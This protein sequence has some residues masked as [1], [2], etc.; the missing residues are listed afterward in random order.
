MWN[1]IWAA[2]TQPARR[3]AP[4]PLFVDERLRPIGR[5]F[6]IALVLGAGF[7]I[8]AHWRDGSQLVPLIGMSLL[9]ALAFFLLGAALG[10]VFALPRTAPANDPEPQG[11]R[12]GF[13][14]NLIEVSDWITKSIVALS[15]ANLQ[16]VPEYFARLGGYFGNAE[17]G[18]SHHSLAVTIIIAGLVAGF[19]MGYI[20]TQAYLTRVFDGVLRELSAEAEGALDR[21][22]LAAQSALT[23]DLGEE[24]EPVRQGA[25]VLPVEMLAAAR[26]ESI[27]NS[28]EPFDARERMLAL[29]REYE[30]TRASMEGGFARTQAMESVA[31]KMRATALAAAPWL[32]QFQSAA[33][34]GA[35]LAAIAILQ[36]RPQAGSLG[37]LVARLAVERPFIGYHAA[38]ALDRAI[39]ALPAADTDTL[40]QAIEQAYRILAHKTETERYKLI[41]AAREKL[42]SRRPQP[43]AA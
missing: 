1:T 39:D 25:A 34:P 35:R 11:R 10:F 43:V 15:L 3:R 31:A 28:R 27:A 7:V 33:T 21:A 16:D 18:S 8:A 38:V 5:F 9:L 12:L 26:L 19:L 13:N 17:P 4:S 42:A 2:L 32:E 40:R 23:P 6:Q 41:A 30:S 37:W 24:D 20:L 29:A 14:Q 36:L 22:A